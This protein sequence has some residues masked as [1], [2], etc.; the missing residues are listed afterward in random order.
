MAVNIKKSFNEFIMAQINSFNGKKF[1]KTDI[2]NLYKKQTNGSRHLYEIK[3]NK[4]ILY[5]DIDTD[6]TDLSIRSTLVYFLLIETLKKYTIKDTIIII[7]MADGY[8]ESKSA[9]FPCFNWALPDGIP[10]F[11]FPTFDTYYFSNS[12]ISKKDVSIINNT[13]SGTIDEI[14]ETFYKYPKRKFPIQDV[15]FKGAKSTIT[16]NKIR[17]MLESIKNTVIN[18][19]LDK[20]DNP[21]SIYELKNHKYLLDLPGFKPWSLRFKYL[22]FTE[23]T[24]IRISFYNSAHNE[25]SYWKQ[26]I[27]AFVEADV[28]YIHLQYDFDY[29]FP[30]YESNVNII[31]NDII[32]TVKK[33]EENT[34][35][36]R[37]LNKNAFEKGKQITFDNTLYYIKELLNTYT[38]NLIE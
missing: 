27:D 38:D 2:L 5:N 17:E 24:I 34:T 22:F 21:E 4:L 20:T 1:S 33:L 16:F 36:K 11:I 32:N 13:I 6:K 35:D 8:H 29:N 30:L 9:P 14:R 15:Y 10:G 25:L 19:N 7:N 37:K 28:D 23:R 31:K 3:N 18:V 26:F 12:L